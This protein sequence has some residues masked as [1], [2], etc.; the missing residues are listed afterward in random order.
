MV[1]LG[2][3]S[4]PRDE[5]RAPCHWVEGMATSSRMRK[6]IRNLLE[7]MERYHVAVVFGRRKGLVAA[8]VRAHLF[9]SSKVFRF[10]N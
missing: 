7:K 3:Q 2:S 5:Q 6:R 8:I 4:P 9:A 10:F 1:I